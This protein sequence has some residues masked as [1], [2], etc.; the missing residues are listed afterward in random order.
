MK[1][2]EAAERLGV[3][4]HAPLDLIIKGYREH[5]ADFQAR[6]LEA[7]TPSLK[8]LFHT[9][10]V[11]LKEAA[12]L[13]AP[14]L[15]EEDH[16]D[17]PSGEPTVGQGLDEP[18]PEEAAPLPPEG[19]GAQPPLPPP[20]PR[21]EALALLG[22]P[23]DA[24]PKAVKAR[25]RELNHALTTTLTLTMASAS[26]R[27]EL[28]T[29][30]ARVA[31]AETLLVPPGSAT[32]LGSLTLGQKVL[33]LFALYFL[34]DIIVRLFLPGGW[35]RLRPARTPAAASAPSARP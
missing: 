7:P 14:G 33:C 2:E 11:D 1:R 16:Q 18:L 12:E 6:L 23:A 35:S 3:E 29:Q 32:G 21:E 34:L 26:L 28:E 5:L 25:A 19:A 8:Q 9:S 10:I 20:S 30:L 22:L 24:G 4:E 15:T 13:L 27:P 17:L 31:E